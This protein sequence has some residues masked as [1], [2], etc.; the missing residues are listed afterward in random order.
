MREFFERF[1]VQIPRSSQCYERAGTCTNARKSEDG[2][3]WKEIHHRHTSTSET[4]LKIFKKWKMTQIFYCHH[5][6]QDVPDLELMV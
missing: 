4:I 5:Q 1:T 6:N 2:G 3:F